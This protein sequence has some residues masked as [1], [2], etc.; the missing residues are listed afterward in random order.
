LGASIDDERASAIRLLLGSPLLDSS[1]DPDDV[2]LVFRNGP[3]LIEWFEETLGLRLV[4]DPAAGFARL[5]KRSAAPDTTR[6]LRRTRGDKRPFDRRRYQLLCLTCASLVRHSITTIG[7]LADSLTAEAALDTTLRRERAAIVD[8]LRTLTDW[9]IVTFRGG[10][11]EAYVD[12]KESNAILSADTHRL[13][14]LLSS[15]VA[16]D[17]IDP[18]ASVAQATAQLLAEPRYGNAADAVT[19]A[20]RLRWSRHMAARA[21]FDDP[22]VYFDEI[23]PAIADYLSTSMGRRLIRDRAEEAGFDLEERT[24]GI[25]AIDSTSTATDLV[26][27][28]SLGTVGQLA[29]LLIDELITDRPVTNKRV[30]EKRV[31]DNPVTERRA[32][33]RQLA[34]I[35]AD[36]LRRFTNR[37]LKKHP[38]WARSHREG[39]GPS[40]L[41]VAAAELLAQFG[42]ARI[43]DD[44]RVAAMP[45][46]ARYRV[47]LPGASHYEPSSGPGD[48]LP[49]PIDDEQ[50][51][52]L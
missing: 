47:I 6:T 34:V 15:V 23:D 27:P 3:W 52:L 4:V 5:F 11:L 35:R 41:A 43:D 2:R 24:E 28:S 22:V 14:N 38:G 36:D 29:L 12:S 19:E 32:G 25:M 37:Q 48:D 40:L 51:L 30:T 46:L 20:Q 39:D 33:A 8:V 44:G 31:T 26:F 10:D 21:V 13:H 1:A 18:S 49:P 45:A 9:G 7:L 42:L 16:A 50:M 17:Q